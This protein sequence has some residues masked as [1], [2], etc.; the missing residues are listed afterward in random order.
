MSDWQAIRLLRA[1]PPRG[2]DTAERAGVFASALEQSEQL[3]RAA[4]RIG[5]AAR[6]LPLFYSLSQAGR[7]IAAARIADDQWRLSGHGLSV[8]DSTAATDVMQRVITPQPRSKRAVRENRRT[9]FAGVAEAVGSGV[10]T[11]EVNLGA[12]WC[13]IPELIPQAPQMP[14][15]APGWR[16]PLIVFDTYWNADPGM[17]A[18]RLMFGT[19]IIV[20]GLPG[21]A[22]AEQI[23]VELGHYPAAAGAGVRI[24]PHLGTPDTHH[25]VVTE[26]TPEGR[27]CPRVTWRGP[28]ENHPPLDQ[29]APE[30]RGTGIRFLMPTLPTGDLL[31]PLMLWWVLLL[32]LSSVARYDPELWISALDVNTSKQAVP[33]EAALDAALV[34]LPELILE[35]L[36]GA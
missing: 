24:D 32:G 10:L 23:T 3:M 8:Q 18:N 1:R 7:A 36:V 20:C 12:V 9:S 28:R 21:D 15:L 6:P 26:M 31:T 11:G 25:E 34:A 33:I 19:D 30:Y 27:D 29:V 4:E 5:P 16:R 17:Q 35:T 14:D 13:A 22:N 2:V